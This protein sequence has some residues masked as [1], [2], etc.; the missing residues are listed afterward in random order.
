[1]M[2]TRL[3]ISDKNERLNEQHFHHCWPIFPAVGLIVGAISALTLMILTTL[4]PV[5]PAC[6]MTLLIGVLLTGAIHEDGFADACDGLF[7]AKPPKQAFE[8][9]KD[10]RLGTF[11]VLGLSFNLLLKTSLL[12]TLAQ[13][14][15]SLACF[16]LITSH[17]LGRFSP[18]VLMAKLTAYTSKTSKL[19]NN[20]AAPQTLHLLLLLFAYCS[21]ILLTLAI[22]FN[23]GLTHTP[24]IL[25]AVLLSILLA[26]FSAYATKTYIKKTLRQYNGDCLGFSEQITEITV[27]LTFTSLSFLY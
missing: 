7:C 24:L 25:N 10:S 9:M 13:S 23:F 6:I 5:A 2:L 1:M 16:A 4:L 19:S 27:L 14:S 12:I 22:G 17:C 18:L 15:L 20:L 3:P 8:V 26:L 11:G 21:A